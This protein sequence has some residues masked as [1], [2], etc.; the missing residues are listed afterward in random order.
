MTPTKRKQLDEWLSQEWSVRI[1]E[2]DESVPDFSVSVIIPTHRQ[3]PIGLEAFQIQQGVCEVIT[4]INGDINLE[5][6]GG[7]R[8]TWQGHS[9][10]R[11][12]AVSQAK[13]DFVLF[14]VDDALP[15]GR[16]CV[17]QLVE[18]LRQGQTVSDQ[19]CMCG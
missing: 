6:P 2:G 5:V 7:R 10:T 4:L 14:S 19:R 17:R 16:G 13:G 15:I 3:R 12:A 9:R 18:G 8:V 1:P 11:Q